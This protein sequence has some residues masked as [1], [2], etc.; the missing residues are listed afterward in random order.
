MENPKTP[1]EDLDQKRLDYFPL[2]PATQQGRL[3]FAMSGD[4]QHAYVLLQSIGH[5]ELWT[6]DL[7]GK[8]CHRNRIGTDQGLVH[9]LHVAAKSSKIKPMRVGHAGRAS[10]VRILS[11]S[12]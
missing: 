3:S 7:R 6:I 12:G 10:A 9:R 4:R 11:P 5:S 8:R 1:I 2:G